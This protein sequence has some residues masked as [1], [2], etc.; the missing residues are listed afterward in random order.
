M[1]K[2]KIIGTIGPASND[3]H[4][5]KKLVL[6]GLN[7]V[8]VNLSHAT[9]ENMINIFNNVKQLREELNV[10]LPIMV[11]TRGPEIRVKTFKGGSTQIKRGQTFTFTG[12][13]VQGNNNIVSFNVPEIVE[14]IKPNQKILAVNGLIAFK[15]L[16]VKG[17]DVKCKALNSGVIGDKKSLAIPG[18][19]F[20]T[21]YLNEK[22]VEDIVWS[23]KN[24]AEIFAASFVNSKEDVLELRELIKK[25]HG[26]QMII[27]K[28]ESAYGVKNLDEIIEYSDG[29]MVARGDL[30]V[31]Y[32]ISKLPELQ[33]IIIKKTRTKGKVVITATE[34]LESMINNNRP[35]RA[36]A[37]DVANA[38]Y[39]GTSVL[40]LSGE[41]AAGKFPVEAVKQMAKIAE[42]TE[43]HI[44]YKKRFQST[45]HNLENVT[46]VI[47]HSVVNA[48]FL[49]KTKV[50]V[51]FTNSGE[52]AKMVSRFR[53]SCLILGAT[54]NPI[55]KEQLAL[56]WGVKPV[57]T[58]VY[59]STDEMFEIANKLVKDMHLAKPNDI[60]AITCGTPKKPGKTN[61]IKLSSVR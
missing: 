32:P 3:Y 59:N 40:M 4:T 15:V 48:S 54:P 26:K 6:A 57:L 25:H 41:T 51:V 22:D 17:Q 47:S 8:R 37:S 55:V 31:E 60:I 14:C 50:L 7:V 19:K 42:E 38:V 53:P 61:L 18:V 58:P 34:M 9:R 33:K 1:R 49:Q 13:D 16:E 12:R 36:E 27:S 20:N 43:R 28:I 21:P 5:L 11:D 56:S 35:T 52:S 46:D 10:C 29:I 44:D 24:G 30:G 45:Q 39:D 23:I 2:T